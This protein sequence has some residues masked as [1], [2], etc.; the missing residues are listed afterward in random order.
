MKSTG[1]F[2]SRALF[3][4]MLLALM[5]LLTGCIG[6]LPIPQFSN[7]PTYGT[8]LRA[9][10]TAFIRV[11]TTSAFAVFDTLSTKCVCDPRHRAVAFTSN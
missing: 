1:F 5:L 11:G 2:L 8:R 9:K 7:Q 3:R 6:A 10:D 4:G